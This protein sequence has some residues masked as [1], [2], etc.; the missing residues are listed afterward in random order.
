M[1]QE[2]VELVRRHLEPREGEDLVPIFREFLDR[3]GP[4]PDLATVLAGWADDPS[5][6][7]VHPEVEW[8]LG[9]GGGPVDTKAT[10][11][12]EVTR[13]WAQWVEVWESYAYRMVEYRDFGEWVFALADVRAKG[14]GGIP[15]EMRTFEMRRVRDG[16]LAVVKIS[17][18]ERDALEAAGLSE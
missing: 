3:L 2:N 1:S 10:G 14:R 8:E 18:S 15:V 17:R 12:V 6:R 7:Y 13:M 5:W 16:K 9:G 4:T 11:P